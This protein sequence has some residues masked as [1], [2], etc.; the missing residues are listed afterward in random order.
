[1][2][3]LPE[4]ETTR[5]GI[6]PKV[7][8]QAIQKIIIRN[9]KL[10]WPVDPSL[11]EKLP[12]LVV[13]SIK[14]RAKY[15]LLE[16][17]Q[18][19]LII[20]LGMS[21]NLRVLPQHEPAV[22]H[23]HIDLLLENGFLLRYHDPRRFGSW[24]WTEAPIQE[25]SLLKSLGPEP[26]TDAFNAEYL[27]QKLQGRKTAIKTFIMN[28]QIVVGVGNIYANESLFLSGI[29]PT[30]PAQ[31]LTLTEA[32]KLTAHIKTVLSAAIEQGGTTLKDFL[33]PDGKPGYFEQKLNVYGRENLPC[34]QC[35]SAIEKVVLNQRAAYFCSNCQKQLD[36]TVKI[37]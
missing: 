27:F 9:G 30:R 16:T 15:L 17:D 31:S 25:H 23:D 4:V 19:H 10:R 13:L 33:T 1:M 21:G 36:S 35:D 22:K 11:V 20:H 3:E 32:T 26:L 29:H 7:E 37:K 8:G 34:P 2:P 28:N 5:K 24:L 14:R 12:G 18:G 6:Q